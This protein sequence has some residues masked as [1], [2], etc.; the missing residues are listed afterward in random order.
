MPPGRPYK[1]QAD[2]KTIEIVAGL[3]QIQATVRECAAVLGVSHQT[4]IRF[5]SEHPEIQQVYED[6]KL[7]GKV[8]LRRAQFRAAVENLNPT[9]LIWGGKQM[10]GQRDV[11]YVRETE[12]SK[13]SDEELD[14][15]IEEML[16]ER[17]RDG[18]TPTD[19]A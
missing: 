2:D 7:T 17:Q 13:M 3:G 14:A 1:L 5:K 18:R 8:S 10:L 4:F 12:F 16:R 9:M 19:G 11:Q 6:G 15:E